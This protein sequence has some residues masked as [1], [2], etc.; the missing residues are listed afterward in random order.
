VSEPEL[1]L[2][3]SNARLLDGR[4]ALVTGA[5][6]GIGRGMAPGA[7]VTPINEDVLDDSEQRARIEGEPRSG[8]GARCRMWRG[9]W[10]GRLPAGPVRRGHHALRRRD[11]AL[12]QLRLI[13]RLLRG[14]VVEEAQQGILLECRAGLQAGCDTGT[15]LLSANTVAGQVRDLGGVVRQVTR[16]RVC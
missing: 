13:I 1:S 10:L 14:N 9:R 11:D 5:T 7:I 16:Q 6:S 3:P 4:R 2:H 12:P 8:V 15:T